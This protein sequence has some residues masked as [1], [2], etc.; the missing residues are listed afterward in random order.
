MFK[1]AYTWS[2]V[3]CGKQMGLGSKWGW[4]S[5]LAPLILLTVF[6]GPA[7]AQQMPPTN[8]LVSDVSQGSDV[9]QDLP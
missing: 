4:K 9:S 3:M 5:N 7:L 2:K 1:E 8:T 6:P